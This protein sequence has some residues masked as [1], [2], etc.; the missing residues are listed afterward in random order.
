[1][2]NGTIVALLGAADIGQDATDPIAVTQPNHLTW[3]TAE[4]TNGHQAPG[5]AFLRVDKP[6]NTRNRT[7]AD[8]S[9]IIGGHFCHS[10]NG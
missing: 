2:F 10:V 6:G 5:S 3:G 4:H 8:G 1:L 9:M 7:Q